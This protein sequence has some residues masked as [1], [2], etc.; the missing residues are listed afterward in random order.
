MLA[1]T[2][3]VAALAYH[4][5]GADETNARNNLRGDARLVSPKLACCLVGDDGEERGT[6]RDE[7]VCANAR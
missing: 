7:H 5:T 2:K 4:D 6:E 1:T 3:I